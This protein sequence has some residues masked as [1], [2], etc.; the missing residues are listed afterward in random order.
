MIKHIQVE[1]KSYPQENLDFYIATLSVEGKYI[2]ASKGEVL[3][4][5]MSD[6]YGE[7][8]TIT[9]DFTSRGFKVEVIEV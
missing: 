9:R 3:D 7:V 2:I 4:T 8:A 5:V 1:V 6:I